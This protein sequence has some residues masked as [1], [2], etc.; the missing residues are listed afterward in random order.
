M[1]DESKPGPPVEARAWWKKKRWIVPLGIVVLLIALVAVAPGG[2]PEDRFQ[3]VEAERDDAEDRVAELQ[4]EL[5]NVREQLDE[6]EEEAET[7]IE[8]AR[9]QVEEEQADRREE[10]DQHA[11]ELDEREAALDER[12]AAI[13]EAERVEEQS[14]FGS[15]TY[16]VG[17]DVPSG[18]YRADGGSACYW[19]KLSNDAD[20]SILQNH[21]G[22]GQQ[23]VTLEE[24]VL[25]RTQDCGTWDRSG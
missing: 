10:L 17:V 6:A 21:L 2:V 13:E 23:V 24:G 1:S 11:S 20:R 22:S 15:G 12:E 25:F 3:E 5:E 16:E 14:T 8:Q 7:A 19:E 9:E 4:S 18:T